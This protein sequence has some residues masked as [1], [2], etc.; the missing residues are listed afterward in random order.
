MNLLPGFTQKHVDEIHRIARGV[1]DLVLDAAKSGAVP[2][3]AP[4]KAGA[5][6]DALRK[7]AEGAGCFKGRMGEYKFLHIRHVVED[8]HPV[9]NECNLFVDG[10][11]SQYTDRCPVS[12]D[13]CAMVQVN[14]CVAVFLDDVWGQ[15]CFCK[16]EDGGDD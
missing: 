11:I 6:K 2:G 4:V 5:L 15:R 10:T 16:I 7:H 9:I 12:P 3:G 8:R 1:L 13:G 14:F